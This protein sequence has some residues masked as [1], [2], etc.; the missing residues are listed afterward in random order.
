MQSHYSNGSQVAAFRQRTLEC[1]R[2]PVELHFHAT[3]LRSSKIVPLMTLGH[4][5]QHIID[6]NLVRSKNRVCGKIAIVFDHQTKF[7]L[8]TVGDEHLLA[9]VWPDWL[10]CP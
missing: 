5:I 4:E 10:I 2:L 1:Y 6:G 7:R 3:S 9:C 8:L